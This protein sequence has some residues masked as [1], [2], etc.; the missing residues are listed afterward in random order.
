MRTIDVFNIKPWVEIP[1]VKGVKPN[2]H[3]FRPKFSDTYS[4]YK[5]SNQ[6]EEW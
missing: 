6:Q 5:V 1:W 4:L 2:T 3:D